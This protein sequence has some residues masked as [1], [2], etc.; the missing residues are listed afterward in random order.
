MIPWNKYKNVHQ[1][2]FQRSLRKKLKCIQNSCIFLLLKFK[3]YLVR[4]SWTLK[5]SGILK[6]VQKVRNSLQ[7]LCLVCLEF[8]WGIF[9]LFY[10]FSIF[11]ASA[12][13]FMTRNF[14]EKTF[15]C[16]TFMYMK[17]TIEFSRSGTLWNQLL[18]R[19]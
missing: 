8:S 10:V 1:K 3:S 2:V 19:V 14:C 7:L 5:N 9:V 11:I 4:F 16:H 17:Y 15:Q 6:Q 13:L 12:S 18:N